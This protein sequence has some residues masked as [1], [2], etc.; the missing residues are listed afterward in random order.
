MMVN[1]GEKFMDKIIRKSGNFS[2]STYAVFLFVG[3]ITGSIARK[4]CLFWSLFVLM[5]ISAITGITHEFY[6]NGGILGFIL[7]TVKVYCSLLFTSTC[8]EHECTQLFVLLG[9]I[10]IIDENSYLN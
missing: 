4:E 6:G 1:D 8:S 3:K 2:Q 9:R 7:F 10:V 5:E